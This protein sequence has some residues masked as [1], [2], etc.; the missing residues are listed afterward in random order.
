MLKRQLNNFSFFDIINAC[1][2]FLVQNTLKIEDYALALS[3]SNDFFAPYCTYWIR[4]TLL[5]R[6]R[7]PFAQNKIN[8]LNAFRHWSG[9][10]AAYAAITMGV[11]V[12]ISIITNLPSGS[13]HFLRIVTLGIIFSLTALYFFGR[14]MLVLVGPVADISHSLSWSWHRTSGYG[15]KLLAA[16]TGLLLLFPLSYALVGKDKPFKSVCTQTAMLSLAS[17]CLVAIPVCLIM[18]FT[19]L[20]TGKL[21]ILATVTSVVAIGM[22]AILSTLS[23]HAIKNYGTVMLGVFAATSYLLICGTTEIVLAQSGKAQTPEYRKPAIGF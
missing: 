23:F 6:S 1:C 13:A 2:G 3:R 16:A 9:L 5:S 14:F 22:I 11:W 18:F 21:S 10:F 15:I 12:C 17:L 7:V 4:S 19:L 8:R 20:I